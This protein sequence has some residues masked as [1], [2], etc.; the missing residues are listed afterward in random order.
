MIAKLFGGGA[1]ATVKA[2]GNALDSLFTSD[3]ERA[4]A[5]IV[6]RKLE[7]KHALKQVEVNLAEA[8]HNSLFVAGWRPAV[9]WIGAIGLGMHFIVLPV[10]VGFGVRV[11]NLDAAQLMQ[12][13]LAMLGFGGMRSWEKKKELARK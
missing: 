11:P 8:K 2:V 4:A 7:S 5:E 9:G 3:E 10:L 1:A 13:V 6:M 12:L